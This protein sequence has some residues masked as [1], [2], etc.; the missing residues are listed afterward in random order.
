MIDAEIRRDFEDIWRT[1]VRP[2]AS[3]GE[4]YYPRRAFLRYKHPS[5]LG[6]GVRQSGNEGF[7]VDGVRALYIDS[8]YP[9]GNDFW[10]RPYRKY[11]WISLFAASAL[12]GRSLRFVHL[13]LVRSK[14]RDYRS[15]LYTWFVLCFLGFYLQYSDNGNGGSES[16]Y[17]WNAGGAVSK[18]WAILEDPS[19]IAALIALFAGAVG[20][21][22]GWW[23]S[24][25]IANNDLIG[26]NL[27][28]HLSSWKKFCDELQ[29]ENTNMNHRLA[30]CEADRTKLWI[31]IYKL[32]AQLSNPSKEI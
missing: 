6:R 17:T 9:Q 12:S 15:A 24:K 3:V 20:G 2:W 31:E 11:P 23:S 10:L 18:F 16:A 14:V 4:F 8:T 1:L 25:R 7:G 27:E 28:A 32:R 26:R 5:K 19:V 21:L 13:G 30:E 29:E 22:F